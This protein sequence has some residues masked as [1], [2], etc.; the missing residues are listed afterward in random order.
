V[1]AVASM[2]LEGELALTGQG[3]QVEDAKAE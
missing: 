1:Q 3:V 2:L